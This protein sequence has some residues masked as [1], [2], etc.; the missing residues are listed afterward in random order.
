[1]VWLAPGAPVPFR[2]VSIEPLPAD[3]AACAPAERAIGGVVY[4]Q[5]AARASTTLDLTPIRTVE[6]DAA[7]FSGVAVDPVRDEIILQD[8]NLFQIRVYRRLANTP[9]EAL[10]TEPKR[11]IEGPKTQIEF[12]CGLYV[13][14]KTGEIY[15]VN[16][17]TT[18]TMVIFG[19]DAEGDTAPARKL[20][21]PHGTYG[22]A[23]DEV[24]A[25]MLFSVEHDN[26]IVTYRKNAKDEEPPL[27]LIQGDQTGL[28]DPHGIAVDPARNWIFV[29]NHGSTHRVSADL[30]PPSRPN[31][32]LTRGYAVPGSGRLLPPSI[33]VYERT[34]RGDAKPL[35]VI[36]G[37]A[38]RLNW[39]GQMY[40]DATHD[41]LFV[42]N[43]GDH[44]ILVFR[45]TDSGNATPIR[46]IKGAKTGLANPTG[47]WVDVAHQEVVV[48]NMSNHSATV[49]A[50]DANGDVAPLRTIRAAPLGKKALAIGNPGAVAYDTT[51][52][53]LLVPN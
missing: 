45:G 44:S 47:V 13:D 38:T 15:S 39:P 35:R 43:D 32:P 49:Y 53:E 20:H 33:T 14:P 1:M 30:G 8:E 9:R 10:M 21:T 48:S 36:E 18:D 19:P 16:N 24:N 28:A 37:A 25:E 5:A 22:I 11:I 50:R 23:V 51:R 46:V 3:A 4:A 42:A 52:D 12:N 29:A 2:L 7:T 34:A 17:D 6:D 26:A 31:W 27:R 41:E 40:F